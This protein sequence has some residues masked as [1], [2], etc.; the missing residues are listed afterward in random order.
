MPHKIEPS[1][2]IFLNNENPQ[3][4]TEFTNTYLRPVLERPVLERFNLKQVVP[5][6]DPNDPETDIEF[7]RETFFNEIF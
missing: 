3:W 5:D 4:L 6:A 1:L 7:S 2:Y